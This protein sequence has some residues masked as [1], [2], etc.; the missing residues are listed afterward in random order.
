MGTGWDI[1]RAELNAVSTIRSA[2][3]TGSSGQSPPGGCLPNGKR[4]IPAENRTWVSL[5]SSVCKHLRSALIPVMW[6]VGENGILAKKVI[7]KD[8]LMR[9]SQHPVRIK[10]K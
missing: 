2:P 7:G 6:D 9:E 5:I 10:N 8:T 3:V 4:T 1:G